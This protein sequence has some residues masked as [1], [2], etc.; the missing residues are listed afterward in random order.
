ML[1]Y[2]ENPEANAAAFT[3]D[4]WYR[5][6]DVGYMDAD[7][8]VYITGRMKSVIVLENGKNVFPEEIEE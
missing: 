7:G 5:T 8:Y 6:G 3:D 4:G 2:F 1:G